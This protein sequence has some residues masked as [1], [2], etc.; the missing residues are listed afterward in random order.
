MQILTLSDKFV[1]YLIGRDYHLDGELLITKY[2]CNFPVKIDKK[3]ALT[4]H[5]GENY[6]FCIGSKRK[7]SF[8]YKPGHTIEYRYRTR[9]TN[10]FATAQEK[11]KTIDT[12]PILFDN[13]V[14]LLSYN[15][16]TDSCW[17]NTSNLKIDNFVESKTTIIDKNYYTFFISKNE[18]Y[19]ISNNFK[20]ARKIRLRGKEIRNV[21]IG[22]RENNKISLVINTNLGVCIFDVSVPRFAVKNIRFF[23]G[24]Y[25]IT[26]NKSNEIFLYDEGTRHHRKLDEY[27]YASSGNSRPDKFYPI[28]IDNKVS[29]FSPEKE[30]VFDEVPENFFNFGDLI[31]EKVKESPIENFPI[32]I[33]L[34]KIDIK[35]EDFEKEKIIL[36]KSEISFPLYKPRKRKN[37]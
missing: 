35:S 21:E 34:E 32:N 13:K 3:Y 5:D 7:S 16:S 28:C 25:E 4:F 23:F 8:F 17:V 12:L 30:I 10:T 33:R 6:G 27:T 20:S 22:N 29:Y 2:D 15:H 37:S 31:F 11:N 24:N 18:I 19:I 14:S 36:E 1:N 26:I 9:N